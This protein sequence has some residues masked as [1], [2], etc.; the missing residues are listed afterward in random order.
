MRSAQIEALIARGPLSTADIVRIGRVPREPVVDLQG[1]DPVKP[2]TFLAGVHFDQAPW[3]TG[4]TL[5][6]ALCDYARE[7]IVANGGRKVDDKLM[8][9]GY[10]VRKLLSHFKP[11]ME[12]DDF[13]R[14]HGRDYTAM[15]VA[16]GVS[17]ST[18]AR[19]LTFLQASLNHQHRE[20]RTDR[21]FAI[22]MPPRGGPRVE[23][24]THEQ[25]AAVLAVPK[26]RR[27]QLFFYLGFNTGAR[28]EAIEELPWSRVDLDRRV[29]SYGDPAIDYKNKRRAIVP[30]NNTLL[31]VLT[32]ARI[33]RDQHE[34]HVPYVI[35]VGPMGSRS[36]TYHGIAAS[37]AQIGVK[38]EAPRHVL[39][40]TF[41]TRLLVARVGVERVAYLLGDTM[42]MVLETY[43]HFI[44]SDMAADIELLH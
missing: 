28:S 15:R 9:F 42:K 35:G 18:A 37:W 44:P 39:R 17:N 3:P 27:L 40:H 19:E 38:F 1:F 5:E 7:H 2:R 6:R 32:E 14:T 4:I 36:T 25:E 26:S 8:R 34:P 31:P 43:A 21:E 16:A 20:D 41:A 10:T 22:W 24:A 12:I 33:W 23:T 30:I 13:E 29:I 11:T